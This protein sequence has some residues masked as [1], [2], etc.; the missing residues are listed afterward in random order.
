[1]QRAESLGDFDAIDKQKVTE[2]NTENDECNFEGENQIEK[3]LEQ[4]NESTNQEAF[5]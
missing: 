5:Q 2:V 4:L 3:P 1:M